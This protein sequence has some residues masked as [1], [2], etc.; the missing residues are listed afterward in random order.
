MF[1]IPQPFIYAAVVKCLTGA[2]SN[3]QVRIAYMLVGDAGGVLPGDILRADAAVPDPV[4]VLARGHAVNRVPGAG[5]LPVAQLLQQD[6]QQQCA[7]P[8]GHRDHLGP[9]RLHAHAGH[10]QQR[11][12]L[13]HFRRD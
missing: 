9:L 3:T 1:F 12:R 6:P 5:H 2:I 13:Q 4:A 8:G 7:H 10:V 11:Q